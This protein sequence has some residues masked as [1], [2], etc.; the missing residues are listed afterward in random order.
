[1]AARAIDPVQLQLVVKRGP[2]H[3]PFQFGHTHPWNIFENHVLT[4]HFDGGVNLRP[5]KTEPFHDLLRHLRAHAI[6][7]VEANSAS[8]VH[9]RG[10]RFRDVMEKN[11]E[12]E[13]HRNFFRQQLEH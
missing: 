3:E 6:V 2:R 12:N 13:R 7:G 11:A 1:M 8:F 10:R 5:G 9:A 4:N